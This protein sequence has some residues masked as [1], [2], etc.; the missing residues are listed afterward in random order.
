MNTV[1]RVI[2][3]LHEATESE[4]QDYGC[5]GYPSTCCEDGCRVEKHVQ[6]MLTE[7]AAIPQPHSTELKR[8]C[9]QGRKMLGKHPPAKDDTDLL[10]RLF[11]EDKVR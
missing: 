2:Q 11:G 4:C 1:D 6:R 7:A 8:L 9:K 10:I 3:R 5:P